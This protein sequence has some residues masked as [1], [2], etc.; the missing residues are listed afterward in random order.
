M[1]F[2]IKLKNLYNLLP[3]IIAISIILNVIGNMLKITFHMKGKYII[4][5]LLPVSIIINFIFFKVSFESFFLSFVSFSFSVSSYDLVK[6]FNR[7]IKK[8]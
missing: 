2:L 4:W 3:H 8:I 1:I 6:Y 7:I 5:I